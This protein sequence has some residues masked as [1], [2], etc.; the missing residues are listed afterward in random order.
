MRQA[1]L[2]HLVS[3]LAIAE[4]GSFRKAA[5]ALG[6]SPSALSHAVRGLEERLGQRLLN[7]T[8]RS[9]ALTDAGRLLL[10][11]VGPAMRTIQDAQ[12]ELAEASDHLRGRIRINAM[13]SGAMALLR[14]AVAHFAHHHPEVEIEIVTDTSLVDIVAAGFDAGVR[15]REAVPLDMVAVPIGPEAAFAVVAAPGYLS[16]IPPPASPADLARHR[17]IRLRFPGGVISRWEFERRG[18]AAVFDP[19]SGL[20]L[21]SLN[22]VVEAALQELG[23]AWVPLDLVADHIAAGRL[24]RMLEEWSPAFPGLCLYYPSQR[25]HAKAL[26]EFIRRARHES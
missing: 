18:E 15:L 24:V 2:A 13:E 7:R 1:G 23:L 4:H 14:S 22:V 11:R 17:G 9:L 10:A 5:E 19:P 21:D 8:T 3:F 25:H 12:A 6:Q 16:V 20:T 26:S